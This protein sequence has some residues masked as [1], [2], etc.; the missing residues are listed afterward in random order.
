MSTHDQT[1]TELQKILSLKHD[2]KDKR[3]EKLVISYEIRGNQDAC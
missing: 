2:D 1:E 3:N